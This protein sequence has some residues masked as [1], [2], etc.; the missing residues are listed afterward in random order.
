MYV[1]GRG[2]LQATHYSEAG[3]EKA[4]YHTAS[5]IREQTLMKQSHILPDFPSHFHAAKK[6]ME[7]RKVFFLVSTATQSIVLTLCNMCRETNEGNMQINISNKTT[8]KSQ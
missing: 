5:T 2:E 6:K 7:E 3:H 8:A 4:S 1:F